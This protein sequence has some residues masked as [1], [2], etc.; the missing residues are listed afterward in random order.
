MKIIQ[1]II[2]PEDERHEPLT[3]EN[4]THNID[5]KEVREGFEKK[6]IKRTV[7]EMNDG[8][9]IIYERKE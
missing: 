4:F 9:K 3:I 6:K 2:H 8:H 7:I 5:I 1:T